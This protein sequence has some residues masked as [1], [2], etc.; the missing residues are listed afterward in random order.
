MSAKHI[1]RE[2][3][4][5]YNEHPTAAKAKKIALLVILTIVGLLSSYIIFSL[6]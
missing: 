1:S 4:H 5:F 6:H 3:A 2:G